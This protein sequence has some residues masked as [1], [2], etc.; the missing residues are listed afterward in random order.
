MDTFCL[1]FAKMKNVYAQ[2]LVKVDSLK[3]PL[4]FNLD[5]PVYLSN[6][7]AAVYLTP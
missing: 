5:H 3:K 6:I 2:T 1:Q 4:L 7:T